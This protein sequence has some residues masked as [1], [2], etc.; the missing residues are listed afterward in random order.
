M[1]VQTGHERWSFWGHIGAQKVFLQQNRDPAIPSSLAQVLP[2]AGIQPLKCDSGS[3]GWIFCIML[4]HRRG[5]M[6]LRHFDRLLAQHHAKQDDWS[7]GRGLAG[8]ESRSG[9][10]RGQVAAG[11]GRRIAA[12]PRREAYP[13]VPGDTRYGMLTWLSRPSRRLQRDIRWP[14]LDH[15]RNF[16]RH[17]G[18]R[19]AARYSCPNGAGRTDFWQT[20]RGVAEQPGVHVRMPRLRPS[21]LDHGRYGDAPFQIAA[22]SVVL[23]CASHVNALQWNV[24]KA[25][26]GS[27]RPHL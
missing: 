6:R 1:R 19:R 17:F 23:G 27:T 15:L 9:C 8:L 20:P 21:D 18:T 25:V 12:L 26:G 7:G 22:Y 16:R 2:S 11:D 24:G 10:P 4:L 13:V 14:G 5:K 3:A